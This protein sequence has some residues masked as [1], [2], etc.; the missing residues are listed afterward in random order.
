MFLNTCSGCI[1][2]PAP[3]YYWNPYWIQSISKKA[4]INLA[5]LM[6]LNAT[7]Y[8]AGQSNG[9]LRKFDAI[10]RDSDLAPPSRYFAGGFG[11]DE[12]RK[13]GATPGPDGVIDFSVKNSGG[14]CTLPSA[15]EPL[16][17]L[18]STG[19]RG[20]RGSS[21]LKVGESQG[22]CRG[23]LQANKELK[24]GISKILSDD[25]GKE[26]SVKIKGYAKLRSR[27]SCECT[28]D[29]CHGYP[30]HAQYHSHALSAVHALQPPNYPA[31]PSG[32]DLLP[33]PY[34]VL[35][36][37]VNVGNQTKR[38]RSWSRAVFSNLQRKGLE[39]RFEVQKYVTKPDRR[40]LAAMLG[41]TD[42][43][44]K[45]WFQNRRMKW[46]HAQQ[47]TT[48]DTE[49]V[50]EVERG[51][52]G[53]K[54]EE[55]ATSVI[56]PNNANLNINTTM[57]V[58][59]IDSDSSSESDGSFQQRAGSLTERYEGPVSGD[60]SSLEDETLPEPLDYPMH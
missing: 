26:D 39:K 5:E 41:L 17:A 52:A 59:D 46:R 58:T 44:V 53:E 8:S 56:E 38:K 45:V 23:H 32:S 16:R 11:R 9:T 19:P 54:P 57:D 12:K 20:Y 51:A 18:C 6:Q 14:G 55:D 24:F 15:L 34:S 50:T 4:D 60:R 2:V 1:Q 36:T 29:G 40:Q 48:M 28:L 49:E 10:P 37:E 35:S 3:V 47:Q 43:Q 30:A 42:A 21:P 13:E 31:S 7:K 22:S 27:G 25:F 33:G